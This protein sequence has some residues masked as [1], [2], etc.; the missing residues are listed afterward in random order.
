MQVRALAAAFTI[1][2]GLTFPAL[3]QQPPSAAN[4]QDKMETCRFGAAEQKLTGAKEREFI[5]KCMAK[6]EGTAAKK[7]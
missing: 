1:A 4:E 6:E 7:K 3:G 5:R 2:T